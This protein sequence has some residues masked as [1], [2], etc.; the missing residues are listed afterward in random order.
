MESGSVR[1]YHNEDFSKIPH[2]NAPVV[3]VYNGTGH[4]VPTRM[5]SVNEGVAYSL[6]EVVEISGYLLGKLEDIDKVRNRPTEFKKVCNRPAK[7]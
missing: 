7:M 4:Y 5:L 2:A 1:H 6:G 3:I